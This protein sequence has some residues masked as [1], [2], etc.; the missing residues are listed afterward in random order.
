MGGKRKE[1]NSGGAQGIQPSAKRTRADSAEAHL[2]PVTITFSMRVDE[3][4]LSEGGGWEAMLG[5]AGS[6]SL[7]KSHR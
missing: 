3:E 2:V 6:A 4:A 1:E 7:P 5:V